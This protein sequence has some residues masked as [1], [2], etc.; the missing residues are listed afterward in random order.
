LLSVTT[1]RTGCL[2]EGK[3][4]LRDSSFKSLFESVTYS[5]QILMFG[6]H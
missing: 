4:F 2:R 3:A 1:K 5:V 6:T